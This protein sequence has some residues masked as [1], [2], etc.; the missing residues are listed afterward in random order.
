MICVMPRK[1]SQSLKE[2]Q[3]KSMCNVLSQR[4]TESQKATLKLQWQ[5][6][7]SRDSSEFLQKEQWDESTNFILYNDLLV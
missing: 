5:K 7:C 3:S 1:M 4:T 6:R 2:S